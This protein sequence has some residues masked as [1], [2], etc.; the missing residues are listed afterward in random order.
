MKAY[1]EELKTLKNHLS[2]L[3]EH[4]TEFENLNELHDLV[5]KITFIFSTNTSYY[6]F[7]LRP[8]KNN[9]LFLLG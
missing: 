2:K 5:I 3:Q 7:I 4:F 6:K 1:E 8:D 9:H